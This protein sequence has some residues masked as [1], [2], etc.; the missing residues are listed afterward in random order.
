MTDGFGLG[1]SLCQEIA[2]LHQVNLS[3][4]VDALSVVTVNLSFSPQALS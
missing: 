1:L 2:R 3:I 4:E